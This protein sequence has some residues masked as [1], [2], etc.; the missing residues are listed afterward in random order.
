MS[1]H[2]SPAPDDPIR[3]LGSA[4]ESLTGRAAK[5]V[6]IERFTRYLRLLMEWNR[7]HRLTAARTANDIVRRLFLDSLLFLA[8]L[9]HGM[10]RM[11]DLGTGP[12]IPGIPLRIVR[13]DLSLTL[14]ESRRKRVSFLGALK[15]AL[16]F[17]DLLVLEGRAEQLVAESKDLAG[18]FDVVVARSVG[19]SLLST[20][21]AYLKPGGVFIA[22]GPPGG[23]NA[24]E[25]PNQS[26]VLK[27]MMFDKLG[28]ERTFLVAHKPT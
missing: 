26:V 22:G 3:G 4:I 28:V 7:T 24:V 6:E 2:A 17:D 15:R 12:G 11:A 10:I 23:I 5:R 25:H 21:L 19:I 13:D 27:T 20:A 1:R 14:V 18:T 9:P 16:E 8:H